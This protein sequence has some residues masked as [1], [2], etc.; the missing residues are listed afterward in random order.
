MGLTCWDKDGA[1]NVRDT[2]QQDS[3]QFACL[4]SSYHGLINTVVFIQSVS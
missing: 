2:M 3:D 4:V 1:V